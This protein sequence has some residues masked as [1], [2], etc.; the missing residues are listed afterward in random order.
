M[1]TSDRI[2]KLLKS[3]DGRDKLY[4]QAAGMC[5][6]VAHNSADKE[7]VKKLNAIAK[8]IGDCRSLMR[9]FKWIQKYNE[10]NKE[11]DGLKKGKVVDVNRG[12]VKVFRI[13]GDM[14][15]I[16]GDNLQWLAKYGMLT[17]DH[18]TMAMR[19]KVFQFWGYVAS[20]YLQL[21]DLL[22]HAG[23]A[24]TFTD[25]TGKKLI[26]KFIAD[27]CDLLCALAT[28]GYVKSFNPSSGTT[29]ALALLSATIATNTNWEATK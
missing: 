28:V 22:I 19:S 20:C 13:L 9:M 2:V 26:L 8:S 4:K 10:V 21:Y 15:Y 18:K 29:G 17:L 25:A 14:G 1:A 6:V 16:I 27:F 23:K 7:T 24:G 12:Y 3:N 11:V 5:K